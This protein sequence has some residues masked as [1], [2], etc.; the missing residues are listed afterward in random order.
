MAAAAGKRKRVREVKPL[1]SQLILAEAQLAKP[2]PLVPA[3]K[4]QPI[5]SDSLLGQL[6][7]D[8]DG[9]K[10][11]RTSF[12]ED[13]REVLMR[14]FLSRLRSS[15]ISYKDASISTIT[16]A[17]EQ[18]EVNSTTTKGNLHSV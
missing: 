15:Y 6:Q 18:K 12:G 10:A 2:V 13:H 14:I 17:R 4:K 8:V 11:G 16:R 7:R 9:Q 5:K 1:K 3:R